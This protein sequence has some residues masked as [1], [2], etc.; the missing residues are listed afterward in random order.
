[1]HLFACFVDSCLRKSNS[2]VSKIKFC[3]VRADKNI[4]EY[5]YWTH[6]S[7]NVHSHETG[8]AD[9]LS[10]TV[11]LHDVVIGGEREVNTTNCEAD[12]WKGRHCCTIC[13]T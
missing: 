1:M 9:G 11:D 12:G 10:H 4:S 13:G 3:V 7:G 5:P 2:V 8:H 6:W